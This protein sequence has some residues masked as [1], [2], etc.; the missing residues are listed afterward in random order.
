MAKYFI[1]ITNHYSVTWSKEQQEAANEYGEEIIDHGFPG[2]PPRASSDSL[3]NEAKNLVNF[4]INKFGSNIVALVQGEMTMTYKIVNEFKRRGITCVA[5]TS[6]RTVTEK[7]QDDGS[8]K[9][10]TIFK[11]VGFREY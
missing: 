9:K 11:F 10:Q 1:N 4:I 8:T 6:E 5:A 7:R 3:D 2:I